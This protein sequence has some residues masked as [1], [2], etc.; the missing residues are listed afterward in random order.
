MDADPPRWRAALVYIKAMMLCSAE[1]RRL[2]EKIE[3]RLA[4]GAAG[5]DGDALD[6]QAGLCAACSY[7]PG[8]PSERMDEARIISITWA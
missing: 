1:E 6:R 8:S 2:A 7:A 5:R 4:A 3:R